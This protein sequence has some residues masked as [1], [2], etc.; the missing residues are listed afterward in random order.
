MQR[1]SSPAHSND[2]RSTAQNSV[3]IDLGLQSSSQSRMARTSGC[4]Q[5]AHCH[6]FRFR[7]DG[8]A[9]AGLYNLAGVLALLIAGVIA[10][11]FGRL[12][13]RIV[14]LALIALTSIVLAISAGLG[15]VRPWLIPGLG[16]VTGCG[17][18][19]NHP[20]WHASVGDIFDK[21]DIPAAVTLTS[22]AYPSEQGRRTLGA[23]RGDVGSWRLMRTRSTMPF[24]RCYG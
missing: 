2:P 15:F 4:H 17:F 1:R 18:A 24:W 19:L 13:V 6:D 3:P 7:S 12:S 22:V 5:L 20:A 9:R 23:A 14:G 21:R 8:R 11:N 16:F 10:D